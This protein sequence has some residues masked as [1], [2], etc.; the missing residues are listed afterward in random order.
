VQ[1]WGIGC[2][3]NQEK[4][5]FMFGVGGVLGK[6]YIGYETLVETLFSIR[7]MGYLNKNRQLITNRFFFIVFQSLIVGSSIII[8]FNLGYQKLNH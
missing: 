1:Y 3:L 6:F 2:S 7:H 4:V 5:G 8:N